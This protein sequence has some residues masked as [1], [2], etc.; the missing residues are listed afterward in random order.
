MGPED[1]PADDVQPTEA[2]WDAWEKAYNEAPAVTLSDE[3]IAEI[4]A[5]ATG[6]PDEGPCPLCNGSGFP[7]TTERNC[8]ECYPEAT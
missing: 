6:Q 7:G 4:V 8:P 5:Y 2:E 1:N 3:R